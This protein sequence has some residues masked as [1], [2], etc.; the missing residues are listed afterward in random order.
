MAFSDWRTQKIDDVYIFMDSL[1]VPVD[2]IIY[3]GDDVLRFQ[4]RGINHFTELAKYTKQKKVL[5]VIGNDD[6][7]SGKLILQGKNVIDLHEEPFVFR[8][9][10]FMG[11]EGSTSGPGATYSEKFVKNHLKK[12]YEKINSEFE[13]LD[14]L[15]ADVEPSR[16]IIVSH[17]PPY[18]ILDYGIRFAQHGTHNI[19]SKSLRNFID[20]NY[21]DLVVCGHCHSQG[22][23]QE[24]QRPCHVANVSSHDDINAQGN[25]ALIDI[26]RDL[27]TK[28]GAKLSGISIRWFNTP[29]L[30]D[31][32]SIQ[33]ISGIGPKT[34]KLFEPVH[35][36]TIQDL[37]GLKNPRKISQKTNIGLNTLKKLQLKA[38]SVIEKKIIQLSP[39]ILPTENAIFL[40]IET[41]VF[42]ERVWLIGAQLNGKFTSF[43]AKNWKE[44]KS[45]LQDFINYLRKHPKSILV[46]YSGT[47]FDKRVIHGALE[48]LKLNSKVFSSIPHFDLCTLLRRCFIFPNQSF[49]LKNLGDYLEYPFKH[50]DLSGFWV[51]V[52]YQMHL[53]ENR[54]LNPKVLP[55]HKDDVKALP[56]ILSKLESDGYTIKK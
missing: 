22:G 19:G 5:A 36:R 38:K 30:I 46:S 31:K 37:A 48:R 20:K 47:N 18:R 33:R 4:E 8:D 27:V 53:T 23:H 9:F 7:G 55:Y 42:C 44:E 28:S 10:R 25:F 24:F 17:T 35:I 54:K 13:Q 6:D 34:A 11:L 51:A 45:I 29:Q 26:D 32:N 3:A 21:T 12:Q 41:D 16:T 40:D 39:L 49:A 14:P 15:L 50:S 2:F 52:E 56:Y 43:Y 1:R